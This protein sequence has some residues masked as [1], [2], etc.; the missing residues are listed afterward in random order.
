MAPIVVEI[1]KVNSARVHHPPVT[2]LLPVIPE[3]SIVDSAPGSYF[4]HER[5]PGMPKHRTCHMHGDKPPRGRQPLLVQGRDSELKK[6]GEL[7]P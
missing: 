3:E 4:G 2:G 5:L 1:T 6:E 7:S